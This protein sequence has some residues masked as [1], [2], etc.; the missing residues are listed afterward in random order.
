[1]MERKLPQM[2]LFEKYLS[3]LPLIALLAANALPLV[4]VLFFQWDA[5]LLVILYWAENVA[6][7]F[8]NILK[9]ATRKVDH[10]A[11][12][13]GK[14][15]QIPFF[16]IHYGGFTG[17]HGIF[18]LAMFGKEG[19]VFG[20]GPDW[21]CFLA[22]VQI[23][24]HTIAQAYHA[25]PPNARWVIAA[26]FVSHGISFGYNYL[27]K[28]EYARISGEKLMMQPYARIVV[29]HIAIIFG[30][31]LT[32]ALGSPIGLLVMLVILKTTID[33]ALHKRQ[34][35]TGPAF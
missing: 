12:H 29:M 27:Y 4:G 33:V 13:L 25:I 32:V 30:G 35:R 22:F 17:I 20:K 10:P 31:F 24:F 26:M 14:L 16:T 15:F 34:H 2:T 5:F 9:M 19:D 18:V 28:G 6:V 8:Y 23:L 7:G 1:M 21:P 11:E 3:K